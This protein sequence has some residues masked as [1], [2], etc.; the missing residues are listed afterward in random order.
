M[1][2]MILELHETRCIPG[3]SRNLHQ[4]VEQQLRSNVTALVPTGALIGTYDW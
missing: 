2:L 4:R 3:G 1:Q